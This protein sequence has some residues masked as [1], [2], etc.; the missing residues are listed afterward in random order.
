[1]LA[2]SKHDTVYVSSTQ[3][4]GAGFIKAF[5]YMCASARARA[6]NAWGYVYRNLE[7]FR[8]FTS[9]F[10]SKLCQITEPAVDYELYY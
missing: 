10:E 2:F 5:I 4:N 3:A 9:Y 8:L 1:M 6:F 7:V